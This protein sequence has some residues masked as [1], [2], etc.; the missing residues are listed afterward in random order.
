MEKRKG[1]GRRAK[2]NLSTA[3]LPALSMQHASFTMFSMF[4]MQQFAVASSARRKGSSRLFLQLALVQGPFIHFSPFFSSHWPDRSHLLTIC[5]SKEATC[6]V[7]KRIQ[8]TRTLERSRFK[9]I[10][11][12]NL[13][14]F[15]KSNGPST[16]V[17]L[18]KGS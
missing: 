17:K 12:R 18:S 11:L 1:E 2:A 10:E 3:S 4:S 5:K 7:L 13:P 16:S 15:I 6:P 9:R 8:G 14:T